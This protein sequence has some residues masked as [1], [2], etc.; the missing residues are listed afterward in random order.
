MNETLSPAPDD[1]AFTV[2]YRDVEGDVR[3]IENLRRRLPR[4]LSASR[5]TSNAVLASRQS[6][7]RSAG[8]SASRSNSESQIRSTLPDLE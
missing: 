6:S 1:L 4:R 7:T 3:S 5:N 2:E 8:A